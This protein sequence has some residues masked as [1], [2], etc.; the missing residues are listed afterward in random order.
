MSSHS[1]GQ[2]STPSVNSSQGV[3]KLHTSCLFWAASKTQK[4]HGY[5]L[6]WTEGTH[7]DQIDPWKPWATEPRREGGW[8]GA[9]IDSRDFRGWGGESCLWRAFS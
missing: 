5:I 2:S 8:G 1:P 6:P 3:I 7:L 9:E 4:S